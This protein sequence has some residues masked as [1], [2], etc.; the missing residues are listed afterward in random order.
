MADMRN[1]RRN[2]KSKTVFKGNR[3]DN[4][5]KNLDVTIEI[6]DAGESS[7]IPRYN[8]IARDETGRIATGN[9]DNDL[10]VA[11]DIVHWQDLS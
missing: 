8:V 5:G 7:H 2:P 9:G 11:I 3:I 6:W 10:E 1:K 4:E